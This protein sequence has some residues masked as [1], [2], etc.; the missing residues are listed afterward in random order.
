MPPYIASQAGSKKIPDPIIFPAT[1][2]MVVSNP[3]FVAVL[4]LSGKFI[5]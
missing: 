1:R 3:I 5:A 2:E 4:A